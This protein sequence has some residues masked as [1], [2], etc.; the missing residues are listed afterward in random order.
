MIE[1]LLGQRRPMRLLLTLVSAM[2]AALVLVGVSGATPSGQNGLISY[3]VYFDSSHSTGALFV[4]NPAGTDQTQ[5]TFPGDGNL[6]TNQN[7]SPDGTQLV[8]EHDTADGSSSIWTVGALGQNPQQIVPC[9][10]PGLLANCVGVFNPSWS[11]DGQWIAFELVFG[12]FDSNGNPADDTIWAVHPDGSGLRKITHRVD[13]TSFD[14]SPQWSPDSSRIA[15]QRNQ[16]PDFKPAIWT[17]DSITGANLVRVSPPGVNGSD[18]PDYSPDG[19]WIMFRTDNGVPGS[20]K[21]MM[22]HPDGTGLR[23]LLDGSNRQQ[24]FSSGFSPDGTAFT[25]GIAPGVGPDGNADVFVGHFD[26]HMR[27]TSLTD[28]TNTDLWESSPRWGTAPLLP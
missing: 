8:Y 9:P 25:I 24:F 20:A 17:A 13:G 1:P 26:R 12:P 18:H 27:V 5:I 6:D 3:R 7:W 19:R 22:A 23:I 21:L 2:A 14:Q 16:P 4:M 28:I 15:F 10:G 11:P